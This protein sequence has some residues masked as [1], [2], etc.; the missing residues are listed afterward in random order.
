MSLSLHEV[1]HIANL[2]RLKLTDE[3]KE[4]F[5]QQLSEILAYATRLQAVET[6]ELS[7][8]SSPEPLNS[9]LRPDENLSGLTTQELLA[10]APQKE[11]AQ[12]RVPPVLDQS[13]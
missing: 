2:A 12:F 10:N 9:Q 7:T 13:P 1:E 8:A 6:G 5:R 4:R 3:E 11:K